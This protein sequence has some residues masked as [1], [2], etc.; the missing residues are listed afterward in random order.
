MHASSGA[1]PTRA[2]SRFEH[3]LNL[4]LELKPSGMKGRTKA[5]HGIVDYDCATWGY[6][7]RQNAAR[8]E[9]LN[10]KGPINQHCLGEAYQS[11]DFSNLR[12]LNITNHVTGLES[13]G[14]QNVAGLFDEAP[15][16]RSLTMHRASSPE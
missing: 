4:T 12:A 2:H 15:N 5:K 13:R 6:S 11:P 10:I 7:C 8:F 9:T 16:L 3:L 1:P 14:W